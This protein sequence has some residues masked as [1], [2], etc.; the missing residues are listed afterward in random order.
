[1]RFGGRGCS[2]DEIMAD[3][4]HPVRRSDWR[5]T[6]LVPVSRN[7]PL[8]KTYAAGGNVRHNG[9]GSPDSASDVPKRLQRAGVS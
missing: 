2:P 8:P 4:N 3:L 1:M 7:D 9:A 6:F 5:D